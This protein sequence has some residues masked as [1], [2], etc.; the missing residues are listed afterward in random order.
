MSLIGSHVAV[1]GGLVK[2]GLGEA[3]EVG[4]EIIQLFAGNPRSW[5]P[6]AA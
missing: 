6:R 5:A 2:S 3:I 4:A 1:A